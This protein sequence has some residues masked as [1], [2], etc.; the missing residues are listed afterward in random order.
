M[1][2]LFAILTSIALLAA[3]CVA[4]VGGA[5]AEEEQDEGTVIVDIDFSD[6]D[7]ASEFGVGWAG[8]WEIKNE[9]FHTTQ[10]W[11]SS[12]YKHGIDNFGD[13]ITV[14]TVDFFI[15]YGTDMPAFSFGIVDDSSCI[16]NDYYGP[17]GVTL[18]FRI[19]QEQL[20]A[21]FTGNGEGEWIQDS[22]WGFIVEENPVEHTLEMTFDADK[23]V[24]V[25]VDGHVLS[26][27]N[28]KLMSKVD[29]ASTYDFSTGY[30]AMK[31][32]NVDSYVDNIKVVQYDATMGDVSEEP[33]DNLENNG[34]VS[35]SVATIKGEGG[36]GCKSSV[37]G[38]L[39]IVLVAAASVV[40][41]VTKSIYGKK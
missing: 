19:G 10:A 26:H 31:A 12:Y 14:V 27:S 37:G 17:S 35:G 32:T 20:Y 5:F 11:E 29:Y 41:V 4:P 28:G 8:G 25:K 18:R 9:R 23:T 24:T 36:S 34:S 21:S 6:P 2:K 3:L 15:A 40:L 7:I 1:K 39:G 30:L 16:A 38:W 33:I 22:Q 13:K